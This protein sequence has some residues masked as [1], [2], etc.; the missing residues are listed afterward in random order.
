MESL[1]GVLGIVFAVALTLVFTT[2]VAVWLDS[3]VNRRRARSGVPAASERPRGRVV[4]RR[5][6]LNE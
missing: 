5:M 4:Y 3:L 6:R 2:G 1:G